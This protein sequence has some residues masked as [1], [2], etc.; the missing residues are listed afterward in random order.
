M[1]VIWIVVCLFVC[2]FRCLFVC[3][4]GQ[5][6]VW[7]VFGCLNLCLIDGLVFF[8]YSLLVQFLSGLV[9]CTVRTR[10]QWN[11]KTKL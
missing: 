10:K 4:V 5:L 2:L 11:R 6:I 3:L 9:V 1:N 8:F 7:V